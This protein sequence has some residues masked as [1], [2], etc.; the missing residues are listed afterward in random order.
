MGG[1]AVGGKGVGEHARSG[2]VQRRTNCFLD[3]APRSSIQVLPNRVMA[4]AQI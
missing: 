3:E 2:S 1:M 4:A